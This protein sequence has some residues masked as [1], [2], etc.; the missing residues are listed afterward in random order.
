MAARRTE[1]P[2]PRKHPKQERS[3]HTVE[4]ILEATRRLLVEVGY[5][6]LS[7]NRV[8]KVAGVSIGSLYQYFPN[9][10]SLVGAVIERRAEATRDALIEK[11]QS[12]VGATFDSGVRALVDFYVDRYRDDRK[13]YQAVLPN[14]E[15]VGR[16]HR[17]REQ[18]QRAAKLIQMGLENGGVEVRPA[19]LELASFVLVSAAEGILARAVMSR[20]DLLDSHELKEELAALVTGYLSSGRGEGK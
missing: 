12:L 19:D 9:K 16:Y 20:E 6:E 3:A 10:E 14:L 13:F 7:T 2:V 17:V 1:K 11:L 4:A 18:S 8:A 15:V 5:D